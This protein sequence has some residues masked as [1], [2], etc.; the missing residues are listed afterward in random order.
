MA[1]IKGSVAGVV[2]AGGHSTRMGQ[3]KSLLSLPNESLNLLELS[4]QLL[5]KLPQIDEKDVL[6]SG[7]Q[8]KN[9]IADKFSN[10]GPLAGI[11]SGLTYLV[12]HSPHCK[13]VL[14][15]PVDMPSLTIKA[16][17]TLLQYALNRQRIICYKQHCLPL[18]MP[19]S[20][21]MLELLT[22]Q[23]LQNLNQSTGAFLGKSEGKNASFSL[24]RLVKTF[25]GIQI[26]IDNDYAFTNIN[27]QQQWQAHCE[28]FLQE[29]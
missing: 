18:C 6:I 1:N 2:L 10:C 29:K 22:E 7:V 14:F 26:P 20:E 25:N 12:K 13:Y 5:K 21:Q 24:R 3:D 15:L 9:G 17:D 8:H 19:V 11:H 16:L 4:Q 28:H 23:L 27:T